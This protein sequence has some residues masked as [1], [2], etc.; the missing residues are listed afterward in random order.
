[1][2]TT[3]NLNGTLLSLDHPLIMGIANLTPDSFY[4]GSRMRLELDARPDILDVGA[5][6][7]R[8]GS[9]AA[10][11]KEEL[12]RLRE[13]MPELLRL[14]G[15]LPLSI[16]TFRPS[17]AAEAIENYG[18]AIINDVS[19]GS[20]EMFELC[21]D[22]KA[23]Y[24]LTYP[25]GGGTEDMLLYLSER[26]NRLAAL[27]VADV[28]LDPGFGF[29]KTLEQNY[30]LAR[31]LDVLKTFG[32][33]ILAGISRKSM[34]QK[35]LGISASEALNATT[36]LNCLLLERGADILRVHDVK[37]AREAAAITT[38]IHKPGPCYPC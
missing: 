38:M 19:G 14:Y 15:D 6:S 12:R 16:D 18:F 24:V 37:A 17:V 32:R 2:N 13:H 3:L 33:P 26:V 36:A 8:P 31:E 5:C 4:E 27:G 22:K 7:T 30:E 35:P 29:G 10:D 1:M 11:E 28:I 21:A 25:L 34:L 23:A 20:D 9:E